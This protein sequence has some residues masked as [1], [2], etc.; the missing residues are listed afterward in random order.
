MRKGR[1]LRY[2]AAFPMRSSR[3]GSPLLTFVASLASGCV[4]PTNDPGATPQGATPRGGSDGWSPDNRDRADGPAASPDQEAGGTMAPDGARADLVTPGPPSCPIG[5]RRCPDGICHANDV[6][7][8]GDA[9]VTCPRPAGAAATSCNGFG[10]GFTCQS[11]LSRCDNQ[12]RMLPAGECCQDSDC[13]TPPHGVGICFSG[14]CGPSCEVT[15]H[16]CD[17]TCAVTSAELSCCGADRSVDLDRDMV[18]DCEESLLPSGQFNKETDPWLSDRSKNGEV[19]WSPM[20]ARGRPG[21]GSMRVTNSYPIPGPAV[22]GPLLPCIPASPGSDSTLLLDYLIPPG[23][24][25]GGVEW[26]F[27]FFS[28]DRCTVSNGRQDAPA[29]TNTKVNAWTSLQSKVA[30]PPGTRSL[31]F[32]LYAA[33]NTNQGSFVVLFDNIVLRR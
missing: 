15:A 17:G 30:A 20:D 3:G 14:H 31:F 16:R 5:Q 8:C 13:A 22:F 23:Q 9:C 25:A 32:D 33:R 2:P 11:G 27:Q 21:S 28:D 7:A 4:S 6:D 18:P 19:D 10:C 12:C 26:V 1:P 24:G 29:D